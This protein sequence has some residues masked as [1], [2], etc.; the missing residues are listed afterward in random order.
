MKIKRKMVE[1]GEDKEELFKLQRIMI[2]VCT[3]V[4]SIR[5]SWG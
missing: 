3:N 1:M 2:T 5:I 4:C